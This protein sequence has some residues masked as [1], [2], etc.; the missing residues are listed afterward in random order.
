MDTRLLASVQ[1]LM[2]RVPGTG[3][4]TWGTEAVS[5][6]QRVEMGG[7]WKAFGGLQHLSDGVKT[8]VSHYAPLQIL[9]YVLMRS[10]SP[11]SPPQAAQWWEKQTQHILPFTPVGSLDPPLTPPFFFSAFNRFYILSAFYFAYF[12]WV[13][14]TLP[15]IRENDNRQQMPLYVFLSQIY[16]WGCE[17]RLDEWEC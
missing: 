6:L 7:S 3:R 8:P 1:A 4:L 15:H 10:R 2:Y 16:R 9:S 12:L 5:Y 17:E 13:F 14:L 11:L